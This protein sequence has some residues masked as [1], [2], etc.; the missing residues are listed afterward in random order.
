[1]D[2]EPVYSAL[3]H[4][5]LKDELRLLNAHLPRERKSLYNTSQ[6]EHPHIVCS[7]GSTHIFKKKELRY[8]TGMLSVDEQKSLLL[9]ILIKVHAGYS[10][11]SVLGSGEAEKKV[12]SA[13]LDMPLT[14]T[15]DG[16][17]IYKQQL[18]VLRKKLRTTTQYIFTAAASDFAS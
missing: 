3:L 1:M 9:P 15:A 13:I 16:I 2:D 18:G 7:D 11:I 17:T 4:E 10:E 8:L 6:E 12:L 14:V 5:A